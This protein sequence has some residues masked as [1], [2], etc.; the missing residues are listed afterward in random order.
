MEQRA[1]KIVHMLKHAS[2][3]LVDYREVRLVVTAEILD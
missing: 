1:V 3:R 2:Q